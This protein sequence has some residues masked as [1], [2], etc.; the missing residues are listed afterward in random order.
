MLNKSTLILSPVI[1]NLVINILLLIMEKPKALGIAF[2]GNTMNGKKGK[3]LQTILMKL[4]KLLDDMTNAL[5]TAGMKP[6]N[7]HR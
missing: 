6:K 3:C 2:A 5:D 7:K 1:F 4:Q